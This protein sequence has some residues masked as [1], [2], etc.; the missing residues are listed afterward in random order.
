MEDFVADCLNRV[1]QPVPPGEKDLTYDTCFSLFTS[2][3][4]APDSSFHTALQQ[5][6]ECM[7]RARWRGF[8]SRPPV[9]AIAEAKWRHWKPGRLKEES[10][11]T[12]RKLELHLRD[13]W[14]ERVIG[15]L[16]PFAKD[17]PHMRA[18]NGENVHQEYLDLLGD[19]R[20]RTLRIHC[21]CFVGVR[22]LGFN[23]IP[24]KE[25]DRS[26]LNTLRDQEITPHKLQGIWNTLCWFS[27]KFGLLDPDSLEHL[28]AKRK[29]IQEGLVETNIKPQRK[30]KLPSKKVI[31]MMEKIAAGEGTAASTGASTS[32]K[33]VLDRYICAMAR[34]PVACSARFKR[35]SIDD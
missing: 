22:K 28:K 13:R 10:A 20:F 18:V 2:I 14:A 17:I 33:F 35:K 3:A 16:L 9:M 15:L 30:A 23:V 6:Q 11:T 32:P 7:D 1:P 25:G 29:T 24:W 4:G 12:Q 8:H 21:L 19:T 27:A 26:L 5:Q 34:F 31:V